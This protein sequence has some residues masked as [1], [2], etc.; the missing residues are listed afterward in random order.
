LSLSVAGAPVLRLGVGSVVFPAVALI[1]PPLL[2]SGAGVI[3]GFV[4]FHDEP[5]YPIKLRI[6]GM[7]P[8]MAKYSPAIAA[9]KATKGIAA[10][11]SAIRAFLMY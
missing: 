8:V 11:N 3:Q 9:T 7:F 10:I 1:R 5:P 2:A 4:V 6:S